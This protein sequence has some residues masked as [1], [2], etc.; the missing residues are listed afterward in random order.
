VEFVRDNGGWVVTPQSEKHA[1]VE[2]I[3]GSCLAMELINGRP[4][5][6]SKREEVSNG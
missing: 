1:R 6:E 4:I 2:T 3:P 5:G